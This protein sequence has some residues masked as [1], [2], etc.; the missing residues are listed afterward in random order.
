VGTRITIPKN[1]I[2]VKSYEKLIILHILYM[3][4]AFC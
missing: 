1:N 4:K 2:A 3:K